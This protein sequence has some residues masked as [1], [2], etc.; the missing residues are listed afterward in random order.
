LLVPLQTL[1]DQE[2]REEK[3]EEQYK[4]VLAKEASDAADLKAKFEKARG[5]SK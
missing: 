4:A 3:E 5:F 2:A 1:V